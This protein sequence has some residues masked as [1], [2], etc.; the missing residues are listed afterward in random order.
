MLKNNAYTNALKTYF[1]SHSLSYEITE[2][3]DK[4]HIT[5]NGV[6][7]HCS[8]NF[9]GVNAIDELLH[10]LS[11]VTHDSLAK[12]LYDL[13]GENYGEGLDS[14]SG[15]QFDTCLTVN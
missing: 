6:A 5:V 3:D 12:N 15:E 10:A 11:E 9:D 7:V 2:V 4:T 13:L 8:R 14:K 1:E